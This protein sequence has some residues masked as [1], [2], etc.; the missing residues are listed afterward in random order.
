M[1]TKLLPISRMAH[2]LALAGLFGFPSA[3]SAIEYWLR[4]EPLTVSMPGGANVPMWGYANCTDSTF[5][6][7]T[8][9]TVPGPALTVPVG[10]ASLTLHLKNDLSANTSIVIPGQITNMVPV[11]FTDSTGRERVR[12]FTHETLAGGG[13]G[14]YGWGQ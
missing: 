11:K 1:K 12:S 2:A 7:C 8:A 13:G 6:S 3:A 14:G 9:A 10:D 5:S 4:A